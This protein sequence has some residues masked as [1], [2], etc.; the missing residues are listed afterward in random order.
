[1]TKILYWQLL[2]IFELAVPST[3]NCEICVSV[4]FIVL[5]KIAFIQR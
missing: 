3:I 5:E 1:M 4:S 2:A